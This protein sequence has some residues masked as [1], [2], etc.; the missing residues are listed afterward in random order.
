[1]WRFLARFETPSAP[2]C[3][4][5]RV[6]QGSLVMCIP[7]RESLSFLP[8]TA[9]LEQQ[10]QGSVEAQ[11]ETRPELGAHPDLWEIAKY[12]KSF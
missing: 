2:T 5:I 7:H 11:Q 12:R 4:S 1:M 6:R 10:L 3:T 9:V 8:H